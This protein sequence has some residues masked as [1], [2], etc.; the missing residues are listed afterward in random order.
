MRTGRR[1]QNETLAQVKNKNSTHLIVLLLERLLRAFRPGTDGLGRVPRVGPGWVRVV[2]AAHTNTRP[3]SGQSFPGEYQAKGGRFNPISV[4]RHMRAAYK[5]AP[6][7]STPAINKET[8]NGR[9]CQRDDHTRY[10]KRAKHEPDDCACVV[11][12]PWHH[13]PRN[14]APSHTLTG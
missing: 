9:A 4:F 14:R 12:W 7:L 10:A 6:S 11:P 13:R 1:R 3:T 2:S 8:P 5:C